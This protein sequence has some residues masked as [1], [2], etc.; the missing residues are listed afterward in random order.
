MNQKRI[1][2]LLPEVQLEP[3]TRYIVRPNLEKI[4]N[5]KF[6]RKS[7]EG[8]VFKLSYVKPE[9]EMKD[10]VVV[11]TKDDLRGRIIE[12]VK[13]YCEYVLKPEKDLEMVDYIGQIETFNKYMDSLWALAENS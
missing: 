8:Y 5:T 11:S 6:V 3:V 12:R 10:I 13:Q 9:L 2:E 4:I 7:D 1:E